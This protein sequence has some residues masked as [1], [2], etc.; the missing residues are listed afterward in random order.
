MHKIDNIMMWYYIDF[1]I[2]QPSLLLIS[3]GVLYCGLILWLAIYHGKSCDFTIAK[4]CLRKKNVQKTA[5]IKKIVHTIL[6]I[7]ESVI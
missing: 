4:H 2:Q 3:Q 5:E 6:N 7:L 1:T